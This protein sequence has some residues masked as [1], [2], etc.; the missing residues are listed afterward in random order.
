MLSCLRLG[1]TFKATA[2]LHHPV[3]RGDEHGFLDLL[4][5]A[6][7]ADVSLLDEEDPGAFALDRD[8]FRCRDHRA[9]ARELGRVRTEVFTGFGSCS[10]AEPTDDLRALGL[11]PA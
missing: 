6:V 4:A 9:D 7:F 5:A 8:G 1:L 11:L 10:V 3:R 2:G